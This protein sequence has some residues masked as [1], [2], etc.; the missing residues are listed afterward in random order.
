[1][2]NLPRLDLNQTGV[3]G[4]DLRCLAKLPKLA[5]LSLAGSKVYD[6]FAA[7][8]GT[9]TKLERLSLSGCTFSDAGLKQLAGLSNLTQLDLTGTQV[10]VDGVAALQKA[11][12]KCKIVWDGNAKK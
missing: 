6:L 2:P 5:E 10:T 7:E 8:V 12:P 11:L 9:L 3:T 4:R 1:L